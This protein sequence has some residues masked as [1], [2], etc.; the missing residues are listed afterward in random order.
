MLPPSV[1]KQLTL[2]TSQST[3]RYGDTLAP[4]NGVLSVVVYSLIKLSVRNSKMYSHTLFMSLSST[5]IF[6]YEIRYATL[7][8][9]RLLS[10]LFNYVN[11]S[12]IWIFCILTLIIRAVKSIF[13]VRQ[14]FFPISLKF[15]FPADYSQLAVVQFFI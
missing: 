10:C 5:G 2:F 13:P 1:H 8:F 11:Q 3:A 9:H 12:S 6:L 4:D 14:K 15:F 7:S